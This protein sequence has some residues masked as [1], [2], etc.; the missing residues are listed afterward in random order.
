MAKLTI[1]DLKKL[2]E[3]AKKNIYLREG[4][5]RG[6]VIVHMGTCGIAAGARE[7]MNILLD[8]LASRD[9]TDIMLTSSGCAG[10]CS[11]EPM[12]TL[13]ISDSAPVKYGKL[14]PDRIK[15]IFEEHI[16]G[17]KVVKEFVFAI[18]SERIG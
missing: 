6:K 3:S 9:T 16:I 11:E 1:N 2:R 13:E 14:T 17:G 18:G 12:I 4:N 10:L 5:F 15:K 7:I 8:E